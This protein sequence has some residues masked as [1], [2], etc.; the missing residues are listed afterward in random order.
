M[1]KAGKAAKEG[2][3]SAPSE[4]ASPEGSGLSG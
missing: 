4:N 3:P 2:G 1:T